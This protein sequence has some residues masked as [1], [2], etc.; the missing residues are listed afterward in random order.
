M[1]KQQY[2]ELCDMMGSEPIESEIPIEFDDLPLEVQEAYTIYVILQDNWEG[3]S[4]TYLGKNIIGI[5]ELFTLY[6][7]DDGITC[8]NIIRILDKYRAKSIEDKRAK[9]KTPSK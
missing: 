9:D 6:G 8:L 4:G 7:I 1:T 3:M 2:F 5:T